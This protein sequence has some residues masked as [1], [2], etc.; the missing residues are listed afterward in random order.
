VKLRCKDGQCWLDPEGS[1]N[2]KPDHALNPG[3]L[4]DGSNS[5]K[6]K[7]RFSPNMRKC[8]YCNRWFRNRQAVRAHLKYCD[9]YLYEKKQIKS[10]QVDSFLDTSL[11]RFHYRHPLS[12]NMP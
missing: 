1:K 7:K 4:D 11:G 9:R 6:N 10:S 2:V 8:W 3:W 5:R 12:W